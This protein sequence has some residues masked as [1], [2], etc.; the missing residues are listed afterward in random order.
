[1]DLFS[2]RIQM[3]GPLNPITFT[4][5]KIDTG[6]MRLFV[7]SSHIHKTLLQIWGQAL[8]YLLHLLYHY[9]QFLIDIETEKLFVRF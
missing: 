9:H 6:V 7:W 5:H 3:A 1:M 8:F 2:A 4:I